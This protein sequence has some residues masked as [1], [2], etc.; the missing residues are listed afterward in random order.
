VTKELDTIESNRSSALMKRISEIE[1]KLAK[2][3]NDEMLAEKAMLLSHAGKHAEAQVILQEI[4]VRNPSDPIALNNLGNLEMMSERAKEAQQ[5]YQKTL[6]QTPKN[7]AVRLNAALAALVVGDENEF[8]DHIVVC[9]EAGAED[10]VLSLA[11]A[12]YAPNDSR[13]GASESQLVVRDLEMA[14]SKAIAKSGRPLPRMLAEK[15]SKKAADT[16]DARPIANY[17]FWLSTRNHP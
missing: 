15:Q 12:G 17:L 7:V 10:A 2:K 9:M 5:L 4:V 11:Q 6:A 1:A 3:K 13:R 14:L 16:A 8:T